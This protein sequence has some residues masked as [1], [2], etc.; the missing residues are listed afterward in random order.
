MAKSKTITVN[1]IGSTSND[2]PESGNVAVLERPDANVGI[3]AKTVEAGITNEMIGIAGNTRAFGEWVMTKVAP[4]YKG[5]Q[6]AKP[7]MEDARL[8][9]LGWKP[10]KFNFVTAEAIECHVDEAEKGRGNNPGVWCMR[11]IRI[12]HA[13]EAKER[14][15]ANRF[16]R[17]VQN[18]NSDTLA[19]SLQQELPKGVSA[20]PLDDDALDD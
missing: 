13:K 1:A 2:Q 18:E 17:S 9:F 7:L 4:K 16:N 11:D 12:L 14:E 15:I 20:K 6:F 10:V 8:S 3:E 19:K 5:M